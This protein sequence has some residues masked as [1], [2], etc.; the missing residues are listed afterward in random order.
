MIAS[1]MDQEEPNTERKELN[2]GSDQDEVAAAVTAVLVDTALNPK[3]LPDIFK[4]NVDCFEDVF[5]YSSVGDLINVGNTCKRLH[6]VA[7]HCFRQTYTDIQ[8]RITSR[9]I[10]VRLNY[11]THFVKFF[12]SVSV[13]DRL[14]IMPIFL[15]IQSKFLRIKKLR[16]SHQRLTHDVVDHMKETLD[17]LEILRLFESDLHIN[18]SDMIDHCANL[19]IL[20][21]QRCE[22]DYNWLSRKYPTLEYLLF[23]PKDHTAI[24]EEFATF[25][26]LNPNIRKLG[27]SGPFLWKN[28]D[29][30]KNASNIKLVELMVCV[31]VSH[32]QFGPFRDLLD[33]L[34]E[35]G[36]YR[37]LKLKTSDKFKPE[38]IHVK[39][40]VKLSSHF[41]G[42]LAVSSFK[43]LEELCM[44]EDSKIMDV[45]SAA[46][47][48]VNLKRLLVATASVD[49]IQPFIRRSVELQKIVVLGLQDGAYFSKDTNI[50]DLVALNRER[51]MLADAA[52]ITL[53][54]RENVYLATK[55]ALKETN[56]DLI[57][58][59]RAVSFEWDEI[60]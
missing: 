43:S 10:D 47:N 22:L 3:Q 26:E 33:D 58:L 53:Y 11:A 29:S 19:T 30:M 51:L 48:L 60:F 37:R 45:E 8:A 55:W 21:L 4:L 59:K 38:Q 5:D 39:G 13:I 28:R 42:K 32:P 9:G 44:L 31:T 24:I 12:Q 16:I 23:I 50:I 25:L 40:L 14:P 2:E 20:D 57:R 34:Y 18:V 36:F 54:V 35:R 49:D 41:C 52:K 6:N 56:L 1:Q 15:N 17:K 27:T 46:I 7:G